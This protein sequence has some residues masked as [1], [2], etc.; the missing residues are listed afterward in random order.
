MG[1][2]VVPLDELRAGRRRPP[3]LRVAL[4]LLP[5][6]G[7]IGLLFFGLSLTGTQ[8]T[9]GDPAPDFELPTLEGSTL[10]SDDLKGHPVV[11]NFWASWCVPCREEAPLLER[12]WRRY[13][14][15]GVVVVGVNIQDAES[16]A[17]AFVEDFDITYP[18]VRDPGEKLPRSFGVRGLPETFF[19]DHEWR[20]MATE[21]GARRGEQQGTVILGAI[22][23]ERLVSNV[24]LL[25]K[26][27]APP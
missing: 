13:K 4:V 21:S 2:D 15:D 17:K 9:V 26:R 8:P 1:C 22:T 18:V 16:D 3:P 6:L 24:E 10:A 19:I 11:V 20:F 27:A 7:F 14:D 25:I 23:E 12:T 5:A